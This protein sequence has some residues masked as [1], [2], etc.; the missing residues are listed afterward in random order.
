MPYSERLHLTD[1]LK[2]IC[3]VMV[4]ITHFDWETKAYPIFTYGIRMAVPI[5]MILSGYNAVLSYER[6]KLN[7]LGAI[8]SPVE[9]LPKLAW[10][11]LPY[12]LLFFFEALS[13]QYLTYELTVS[14]FIYT[15]LT[16]GFGDGLSGGYYVACLLELTLT[17]PIIYV[18][19]RRFPKGGLVGIFAFNFLYEVFVIYSGM[20]WANYRIIYLRYIFMVA[21]GM[22]MALGHKLHP[23][24]VGIML[25]AG[26][27]YLY[28]FDYIG[29]NIKLFKWWGNTNLPAALYIVPVIYI[30]FALFAT[31]QLP[32]A[33]GSLLALLGRST[34]HIFL[35]QMLYYRMG[36]CDDFLYLGAFWN[37]TL[38]ILICCFAGCA[39][40]RL[41]K[42]F[43]VYLK[44]PKARK[45]ITLP[46]RA[47]NP[48]E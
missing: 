32:S 30:L 31:K 34:W 21:A 4:I 44:T 45:L 22:Y 11:M 20:S 35:F 12:T 7:T 41:E 5:F 24:L 10:I 9:M 47:K 37:I 6:H 39:W 14:D 38:N 2:A 16:G 29:L 25:A 1:Y 36:W 40:S 26:C 43:Q 42:H 18:I 17:M 28:A 13:A 46:V 19:M 23:A 33:V 27:V 8:Y 48:V 3:I 15:Y